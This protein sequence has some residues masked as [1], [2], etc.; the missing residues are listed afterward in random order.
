MTGLTAATGVPGP[1]H[2][3]SPSTQLGS[4]CALPKDKHKAGTG[5]VHTDKVDRLLW[6]PA[7]QLEEAWGGRG[8]RAGPEATS[9]WSAGP[10]WSLHH[11]PGCPRQGQERGPRQSPVQGMGG[12]QP[13]A[14]STPGSGAGGAQQ[15]MWGGGLHT[16][17]LTSA[18]WSPGSTFLVPWRRK[19]RR[20][21]WEGVGLAGVAQVETLWS[22]PRGFIRTGREVWTDADAASCRTWSLPRGDSASTDSGH[23]RVRPLQNPEPTSPALPY[24]EAA[25][26]H[27]GERLQELGSPE[28]AKEGLQTEAGSRLKV[29][30]VTLQPASL[31]PHT[32]PPAGLRSGWGEAGPL[33]PASP[34][35]E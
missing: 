20:G 1:G 28:T 13:Q 8:P 15:E 25:S 35:L 2:Q 33:P 19:L 3:A 16:C 23:G 14:P 5:F 27:T 32:G 30:R 22:D 6:P 12:G 24:G 4:G 31:A 11:Q 26:W 29:W 7:R 21:L 9:T 17:P 10:L 18:A 34:C